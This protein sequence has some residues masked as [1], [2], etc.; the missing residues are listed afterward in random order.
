MTMRGD[1][2]EAW[3]VYKVHR[4]SFFFILLFYFLISC[5]HSSIPAELQPYDRSK[6]EHQEYR[7]DN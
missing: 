7:Q 6:I 4:E 3:G 5:D 1:A 2:G